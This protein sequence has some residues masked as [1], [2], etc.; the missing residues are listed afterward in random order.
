M[1]SKQTN[2]SNETFIALKKEKEKKAKRNLT[3]FALNLCQL[4]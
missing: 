1:R 3:R 2:T 4:K